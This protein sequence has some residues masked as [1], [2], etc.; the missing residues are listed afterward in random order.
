MRRWWL[1]I[2]LLLSLGVNVGVL[3]TVTLQRLR[4]PQGGGPP[5]PQL[6]RPNPEAVAERLDLEGE[7]REKFVAIQR[8]FF[9]TART[10]Q[11]HLQQ[12][13]QELRR[14]LVAEHSDRAQAEAI[15]REMAEVYARLE[16]ALVASILDSKEILTPDQQRRY[17][18]LVAARLFQ[19]RFER[20]PQP[21]LR[22]PLW[23]RGA[24]GGEPSP[25]R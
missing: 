17:L 24:A 13:R 22:R 12:L 1:A 16:T 3:A 23:R 10:E 8:R 11:Q 21:P 6:G 2:A 5:P 7:T 18:R 25:P 4:A 19:L 9:E 14:D 20:P 15:S